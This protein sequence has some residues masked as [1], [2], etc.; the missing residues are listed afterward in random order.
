MGIGT[1]SY[2]ALSCLLCR[3]V[4]RIP[5]SML[6]R[7]AT[8][9]HFPQS[10]SLISSPPPRPQTDRPHP[11]APVL[12]R[13]VPPRL[14]QVHV[15]ARRAG[16]SSHLSRPSSC[17]TVAMAPT[18]SSVVL[19]CSGSRQLLPRNWSRPLR[20]PPPPSPVLENLRR[21]GLT[22]FAFT[23]GCLLFRS[24]ASAG[25]PVPSHS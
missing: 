13:L 19:S 23:Y 15:P 12:G 25:H 14:C 10:F 2:L 9:F 16:S 6:A 21:F 7:A 3:T 24:T 17:V 11:R 20:R 4:S 1:P 5:C 18:P 8:H 22:N